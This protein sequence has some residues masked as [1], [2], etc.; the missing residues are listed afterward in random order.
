VYLEAALGAYLHA[1][2]ALPATRRFEI[3]QGSELGRPSL[4]TVQVPDEVQDGIRVSGAAVR[5]D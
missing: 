2:H 3:H 1:Q 4:L 5:I